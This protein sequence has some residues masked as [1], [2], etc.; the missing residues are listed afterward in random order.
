MSVK[1]VVT[2][3]NRS[4][5]NC[6]YRW[7][8]HNF[9]LETA[10]EFRCRLS[11]AFGMF[12]RLWLENDKQVHQNLNPRLLLSHSS[13]ETEA[14]TRLH[15]ASVPRQRRERSSRK[16]QMEVFSHCWACYG[17]W[18]FIGSVNATHMWCSRR[19]QRSTLHF[20]DFFYKT[21]N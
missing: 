3:S 1:W 4:H 13:S 19:Q 11:S 9:V 8:R 20:N 10:P 16:G 18:K 7:A 21:Y 14:G 2:K 17:K 15:H 6:Q 12:T 5:L